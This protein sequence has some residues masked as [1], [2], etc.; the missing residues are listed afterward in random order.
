MHSRAMHITGDKQRS[1]GASAICSVRCS[2]RAVP[3]KCRSAGTIPGTFSDKVPK[4]RPSDRSNKQDSRINRDLPILTLKIDSHSEGV[5]ISESHNTGGGSGS[6]S[7]KAGVHLPLCAVDNVHKQSPARP[8]S[9]HRGETAELFSFGTNDLTQVRIR[10]VVGPLLE[11]AIA[12]WRFVIRAESRARSRVH[13]RHRRCSPRVRS[14][15]RHRQ[16]SQPSRACAER[17]RR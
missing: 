11:F 13:R 4:R 9:V 15:V 17:R 3:N 6:V 16:M 10:S 5:I 2:A 14:I 12:G 1:F 7:G 8:S